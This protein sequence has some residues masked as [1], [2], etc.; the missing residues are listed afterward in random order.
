MYPSQHRHLTVAR[1]RTLV[2][3][4]PAGHLAIQWMGG[5]VM[6]HNPDCALYALI[7]LAS[8]AIGCHRGSRR[9]V[10]YSARRRARAAIVDLDSMP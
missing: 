2:S 8:S 1:R 3:R 9:R 7:K 4:V 10:I 5:E 6:A